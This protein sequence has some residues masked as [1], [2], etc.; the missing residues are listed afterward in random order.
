ME[1]GNSYIFGNQYCLFK[2]NTFPVI[3]NLFPFLF[4]DIIHGN[5]LKWAFYIKTSVCTA[6]FDFWIILLMAHKSF[7]T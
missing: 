2:N 7:C 4:V 3:L 6:L 1:L 5:F